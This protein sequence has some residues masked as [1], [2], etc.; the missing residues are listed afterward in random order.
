MVE[1]PLHEFEI[2]AHGEFILNTGWSSSKRARSL[3][4]GYPFRTRFK[5]EL[6]GHSLTLD[7]MRY[8]RAE[9][10]LR[11]DGLAAARQFFAGCM[12]DS[13]PSRESVW[14]AHIDQQ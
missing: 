6:T 7:L 9:L 2:L 11:L 12:A 4:K 14:V 13:D 10:P 1:D 5:W 3:Q 8:Q